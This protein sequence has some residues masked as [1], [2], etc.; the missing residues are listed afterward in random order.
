MTKEMS[1]GFNLDTNNL[2]EKQANELRDMSQQLK[3]VYLR[4]RL[5]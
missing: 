3:S 1:N 4:L 5:H 2:Q